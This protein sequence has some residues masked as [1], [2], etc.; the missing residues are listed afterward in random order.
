MPVPYLNEKNTIYD[1]R[2][3]ALI[4]GLTFIFKLIVAYALPLTGDE[5]YFA[6]WG[7]FIALGY[8]DH[9]PL[10]GWILY[11]FIHLSNAAWVL[12]LPTIITS[13]LIGLGIYLFIRPYNINKAFLVSTL[14]LISPINLFGVFV[15]TDTPLVFCCF[16]SGIFL[17]LALKKDEGDNW[18]YYLL[19]GLM[20]GLALLAKYFAVLLAIAYVIGFLVYPKNRKRSIGFLLLFFSAFLLASINLYWNYTHSWANLLFNLYNRNQHMTWQLS[21]VVTYVLFL[22]YLL[23][24]PLLYYFARQP[25]KISTE[26]LHSKFKILLISCATPLLLLLCL[27]MFRPIGLHWSLAFIPLVYLIAF[28]VLLESELIICIRWVA[29]FSAIHIILLVLILFLPLSFYQRSGIK[30]TKYASLVFNLKH[31]Q[32]RQQLNP[33]EQQG[34]IICSTSY[35]KSTLFSIDSGHYSPVFG[36]GTFHARHDDLLTDFKTLQHK[37]FAIFLTKLPNL[38]NFSPYFGEISIQH[39]TKY[40]AHFYVILGKNFN[41]E[42][43]RDVVL[44]T[45]Y[46]RYWQIPSYLPH[47]G[48]LYQQ[49]YSF[50]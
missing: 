37:N 6:I 27:S 11:P 13:S 8:Y 31:R 25:K 1:M 24:P 9:P 17:F 46:E 19:S 18:W 14:F 35:A 49:K 45:I 34:Y 21:T 40:G 12:R 23:S 33:Y 28:K 36:K 32:I 41:Y 38:H 16:L 10:I 22:L 43:Y 42:K 26:L 47:T 39:F 48:N 15:T 20:L 30:S 5:A 3:I 50:N 4:L 7:K 44:R 2:K 29:I